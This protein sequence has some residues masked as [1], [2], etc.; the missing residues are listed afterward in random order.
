MQTIV[1]YVSF[2][3]YSTGR[4]A[5]R[6]K[7]FHARRN[8]DNRIF[9]WSET[10]IFFAYH[11]SES[12]LAITLDGCIQT[13]RQA[14]LRRLAVCY[15]FDKVQHGVRQ[16]YHRKDIEHDWGERRSYTILAVQSVSLFQ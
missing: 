16:P 1:N 14:P 15:A 2:I 8:D 6:Y 12:P 7:S 3:R 11:F 13:D 9:L 5:E 4:R 10:P